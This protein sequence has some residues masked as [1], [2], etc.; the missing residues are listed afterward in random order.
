[1]KNRHPQTLPAPARRA[2]A[3][4]AVGALLGGAALLLPTSSTLAA[5]DTSTSGTW[6]IDSWSKQDSTTEYWLSLRWTSGQDHWGSRSLPLSRVPG[7]TPAQVG[8]SPATVHFEIRRDAGTFVCDG[9]VGNDAGAGLY[10][11]KLDPA[12][13]DALAK[14]GI[15]RPD[16]DQQIR[17]AISDVSYAFLDEL[18]SQKYPKPDLDQLVTLANHGVDMDSWTAWA[19]SA[20]GSRRTTTW[21]ARATTAS[22][23]ATCRP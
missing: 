21:C 2:I 8:G 12:Y 3:S 16:T 23:R 7:L 17:F 5:D 18:K 4:L 14:R 13:A 6:A 11:L 10:D 9:R 20:T 19:R 1:M 15:G 22:I